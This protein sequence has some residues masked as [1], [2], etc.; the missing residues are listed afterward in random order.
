M[1]AVDDRGTKYACNQDTTVNVTKDQLI[2]RA[3]RIID[4]IA[5]ESTGGV[6][7]I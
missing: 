3:S 2:K 7:A 1:F 6:G 4:K 5:T